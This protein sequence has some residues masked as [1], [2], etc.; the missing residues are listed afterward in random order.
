MPAD[1]DRADCD[2]WLWDGA[3]EYEGKLVRLEER[4]FTAKVRQARKESGGAGGLGRRVPLSCLDLQRQFMGRRFLGHLDGSL[5]GTLV[6]AE[7]ENV[8][9]SSDGDFDYLVSG[10]FG[11]LDDAQVEMLAKMSIHNAASLLQRRATG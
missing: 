8:Q 3:T 6:E 2:M 9:R 5:D 7:V 1:G 10:R 11:P 4:K